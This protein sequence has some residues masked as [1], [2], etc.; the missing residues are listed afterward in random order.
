[1]ETIAFGPDEKMKL[2]EP[3]DTWL[4]AG[5]RDFAVPEAVGSSARVFL[6]DYPPLAGDYANNPVIKVMRPDKVQYALPLFQSEVQILTKMAGAPGITPMLGMGFMRVTEG[7]WPDEIAPLT[8]SLQEESS[9]SDMTGE[10]ELYS[11][12]EGEAFLAELPERVEQGWLAAILLPRRWEDNLYLRCDAG[13]TRGEFHR[14]FSV[15]S[16]LQAAIQICE[17]MEAAHERGIIYLDHK[18]LHYYWNEPRQQVYVLDWNIGRLIENGDTAE[19]YAFDVLQFSARA[20][21]HLLTGRQAPGSV[22]VGPN[23]PEDIQNAPEKY[24]P[25]WTYDDQKRLT[26]DELEVLSSAIQSE[27]KTPAELAK[28]LQPLYNQRQSQA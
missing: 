17:I 20:L 3:L 22:K 19:S 6:L 7:R 24:E 9:A 4:S 26:E 18:A 21:H 14:S 25:V 13:Y 2:T 1:M 15:A 12:D 8:T 23:R 5:L 28:A 16:A 10:F 11:P 27:Y